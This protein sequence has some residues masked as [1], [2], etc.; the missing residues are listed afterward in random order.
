MLGKLYDLAGPTGL[1]I[2]LI[3]VVGAFVALYV[4][5]YSAL[6]WSEFNKKLLLL[7][8][9]NEAQRLLLEY[10]GVNP[11]LLVIKDI[12]ARGID[13]DDDLQGETSVSFY[14]CFR[15]I[16]TSLTIIKIVAI[17]S[18]L[19]GL[20]G[21]VLGMQQIFEVVAEATNPDT[22]LLAKGIWQ[23]LITTIMGLIVAIPLLVIYH[24]VS[25]RIKR[26]QTIVIKLCYKLVVKPE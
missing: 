21:T 15:R 25:L 4:I 20:L 17:I 18:P 13:K 1:V 6:I 3:G 19:L 22:Q 23:A 11:F 26:F 8:N 2:L 14:L 10:S 12:V 16:F 24:L 7:A 5:F 9:K